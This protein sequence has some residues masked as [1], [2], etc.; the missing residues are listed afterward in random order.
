MEGSIQ[1]LK[2]SAQAWVIAFWVMLFFLFLSVLSLAC[3]LFSFGIVLELQA[4]WTVWGVFYSFM[5]VFPLLGMGIA[6]YFMLIYVKKSE[7]SSKAG[8]FIIS[9]PYAIILTAI[10]AYLIYD[11][12]VPCEQNHEAHCWDGLHIRWQYWWVWWSIFFQW[13]FVI[14]QILFTYYVVGSYQV[15]YAYELAE[16]PMERASAPITPVITTP[17]STQQKLPNIST[18]QGYPNNMGMLLLNEVM[19]AKR[20]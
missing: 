7:N 8:L 15:L 2:R 4:G 16:V 9:V 19:H 11:I 5:V 18:V 17:T 1:V 12:I 13:L 3:S 6:L 20:N 14:L 10:F